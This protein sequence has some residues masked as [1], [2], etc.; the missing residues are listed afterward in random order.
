[1]NAKVS[2]RSEHGIYQGK[3]LAAQAGSFIAF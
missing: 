1:M 3:E 2:E